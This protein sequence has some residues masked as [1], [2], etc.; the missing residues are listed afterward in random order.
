MRRGLIEWSKTELPE[1]VFDTRIA[2]MRTAMAAANIDTLVAY[3]NFTRPSAVSWLASF[4]PYWSECA[5]VV[6]KTGPL[7]MVSAV[8][9]RGRPWIQ[10]TTYSENLFFSPKIGPE[11]ARVLKEAVPPSATIGVVELDAIPA[12]VGLALK[13]VGATLVD[14]TGAFV[15]ARAAGDAASAALAKTA[16]GFAH[17]AL[18]AFDANAT[19][20]TAVIAAVDLTARRLGA[21][22]SY[23]AIAVNAR[24]DPR[25]LRLEGPATLG[26]EFAV[27]ATVAYKGT[28]VRMVRTVVRGDTGLVAK[29]S[30]QFAAA[31]ADLPKLDKLA[32]LRSYLVETART[33][34]PLEAVAGSA[35]PQ[36][37]A[38]APGAIVTVQALAIVDGTPILLGAPAI[39]GSAGAPG[40]FLVAP[41]F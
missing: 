40:A 16:A 37:Q 25:F 10:S 15:S 24:K 14:A 31:V 26:D 12:A 4:I 39:A 21:E 20:A 8:S 7:S 27:R 2:A 29:A 5:L 30:A 11:T 34:Q 17:D 35:V 19:D 22:E 13:S 6:P 38:F 1:T 23:V 36:P 33:A 9:P 32:A 3:T 18:A 41:T 28:W